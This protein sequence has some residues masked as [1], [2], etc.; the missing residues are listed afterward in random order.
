VRSG[1]NVQAVRDALAALKDGTGDYESVKIAVQ[2]ARF[3]ARPVARTEADLA[4]QWD[5][6]TEPDSFTDTVRVAQWQRVLTRAQVKELMGMARFMGPTP[7]T[8]S[9]D[10]LES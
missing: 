6:V 3:V 8:T 5:Y 10:V 4:R 9:P 2:Q 7:Q 1:E